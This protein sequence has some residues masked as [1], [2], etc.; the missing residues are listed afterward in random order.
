MQRNEA[1][2]GRERA[3]LPERITSEPADLQQD[4]ADEA[5]E[6]T[7]ESVPL[8]GTVL[9]VQANFY[10]VQLE[11]DTIPLEGAEVSMLLCTR[12]ARLKKIGQQVMVGDRVQIEEPD[13][14]GGRGAI[15]AVYPRQTE[16]DRPRIANVDQILLV[17]ALAEPSLEPM[18][19]SR[20]L[21]K[22]E[23]TEVAVRLCL[24]K[25][26]LLSEEE[27]EQ[28]R[29]RLATWG[30]SPIFMSVQANTGLD[31]LQESLEGHITLVSGPSGVGKSSLLNRL[32]PDVELRVG[33]VS[34]KLRH[35]RHT[36]RHVELFELA[37]GGLLAD[38]PGFNQPDLYCAPTELAHFFPEARERLSHE[39]CQF[40]DCLH[41]D[42]PGCA[43]RGDWE[44]YEY[45][46]TFLEEAIARQTQLDRTPDVESTTKQKIRQSGQIET[47][48]KL[49]Q[50]KYRRQSRRSGK[51]EL[52]SLHLDEVLEEDD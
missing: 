52:D 22:A 6:Q 37:H 46:L 30:Y 35:G 8:I 39:F 43:V 41:R 49:S 3:E 13:W 24:N 11:S 2:L 4:D 7:Q 28:W 17:F 31:D 1:M 34:G 10:S 44:R 15:S 36:T 47:E 50:K 23:S 45:Y 27:R 9:A 38:S 42:E 51:Q 29:D 19:L 21:V 16:L 18:Q 26:D 33:E 12:R 40:N 14:A 48:P 20:F 25:Q 32:L 5:S